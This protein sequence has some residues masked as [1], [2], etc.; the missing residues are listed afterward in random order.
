M[1]EGWPPQIGQAYPD[2]EMI[3]AAGARRKLSE[4]KGK[5]IVLKLI[6]M[7]CPACNAFS[8]AKEK[9]GYH[10]V[11]PQPGLESF[12]A[13]FYQTTK[14]ASLSDGRIAVVNL[15]LYNTDMKAP[16]PEE[17]KQWTE[18]FKLNEK[19]NHYVFSGGAVLATKENMELIPGFQLIDPSF[20]LHKDSSGHH[21]KQ[22]LYRDLFPAIP[23]L[24]K[25]K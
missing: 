21:P 5:V 25:G 10:G 13:Y 17:V 7:S 9:G 8:G 24:L 12:D 16:S 1:P 18:H 4:F 15:L 20:V 11:K 23:A 22:D 6:G 14:G 19:S 2:I 3:D